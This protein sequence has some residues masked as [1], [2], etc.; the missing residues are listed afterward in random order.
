MKVISIL[1]PKGGAGKTVSSVNI[2]SKS[3]LL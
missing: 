2:S 3:P 1:N